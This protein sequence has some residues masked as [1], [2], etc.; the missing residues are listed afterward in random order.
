MNDEFTLARHLR[1]LREYG[2]N[3]E[4]VQI[5]DHR[6]YLRFSLIISGLIVV[7]IGKNRIV[8]SLLDFAGGKLVDVASNRGKRKNGG[9]I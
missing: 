1:A 6:F 9:R 5:R 4:N 3:P 7:S 2:L 8:V